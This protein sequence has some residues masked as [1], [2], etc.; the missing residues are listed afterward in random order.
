MTLF[1]MGR[2]SDLPIRK[3]LLL[4]IRKSSCHQWEGRTILRAVRA[5]VEET[6]SEDE[7]CKKRDAALKDIFEKQDEF[8]KEIQF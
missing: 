3:H 8:L 4:Q 6:L 5:H 7:V 2:Q 1:F